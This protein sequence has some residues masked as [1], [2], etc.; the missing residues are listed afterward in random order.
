MRDHF[1]ADL[2]GFDS[3][4]GRHRDGRGHRD[5]HQDAFD[6][7]MMR[8]ILRQQQRDTERE[9]SNVSSKKTILKRSACAAKLN[10]L[11]AISRPSV[12]A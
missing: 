2:S 9:P 8:R 12:S 10:G 7:D 1:P 5:R 3:G 4:P 6:P 11:R